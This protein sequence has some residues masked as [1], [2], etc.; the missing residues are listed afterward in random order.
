[1]LLVTNP[2]TFAGRIAKRSPEMNIKRKLKALLPW[3][4]LFC[5]FILFQG[6]NCQSPI[7]Q[8]KLQRR[9]FNVLRQKPDLFRGEVYLREKC[10]GVARRLLP[11]CPNLPFREASF[12]TTPPGT[13]LQRTVTA[14]MAAGAGRGETVTAPSFRAWES[15]VRSDCIFIPY[16]GIMRGRVI[17]GRYVP[18]KWLQRTTKQMAAAQED[19]N[20]RVAAD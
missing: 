10:M 19:Y 12:T 4:V 16:C 17:D 20:N 9:R 14:L 13:C 18:S 6:L 3:M 1:M 2:P 7:P 15:A 8:H 11:W 5:Q